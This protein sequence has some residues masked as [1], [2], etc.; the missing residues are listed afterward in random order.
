MRRQRLMRCASDVERDH[1]EHMLGAHVQHW[2]APVICTRQS[3]QRSGS[4][5]TIR[6]QRPHCGPCAQ[7]DQSG[8]VTTAALERLS[9]VRR[10]G[11]RR[12]G[13]TP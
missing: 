7:Q 10:R 1:D 9:A 3:S 13:E 2:T 6:G 12:V 11:G 8:D 5:K 4:R